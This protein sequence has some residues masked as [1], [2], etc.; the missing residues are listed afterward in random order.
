VNGQLAS[1]GWPSNA[2][3]AYPEI[4]YVYSGAQNNGQI[5]QE[6]DTNH[7]G[8]DQGTISYQYL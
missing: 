5:T 6:I 2:A 4:Q 7:E 1:I 3:G 8:M